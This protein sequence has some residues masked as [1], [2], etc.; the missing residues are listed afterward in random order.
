MSC[1]Q[2]LKFTVPLDQDSQNHFELWNKII[3]VVLG[4][5]QG[6]VVNIGSLILKIDEIIKFKIFKNPLTIIMSN[7]R[8]VIS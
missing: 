6:G 7:N 5:K 1:G 2:V 3:W 4:Y 8:I